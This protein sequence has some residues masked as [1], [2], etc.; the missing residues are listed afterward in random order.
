MTGINS[1]RCYETAQKP[2]L[3]ADVVFGDDGETVSLGWLPFDGVIDAV[4]VITTTA[5]DAGTTNQIDI[6]FRSRGDGVA[7]DPDGLLANVDVSAA[8]VD[9]GDLSSTANLAF[10]GGG[11]VTA[12]IDLV[13]TA[14]TAGVARVL[15]EYTY[16]P[17]AP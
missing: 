8:G 10:T 4:K 16:A 7:D 17:D 13:G 15:V 3:Y 11:E 2:Y 12:T 6:G 14:A 1:G 5:F 9:T